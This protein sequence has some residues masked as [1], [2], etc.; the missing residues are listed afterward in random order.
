VMAVPA[1]PKQALRPITVPENSRM[2]R[3]LPL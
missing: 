2:D 3:K 1:A